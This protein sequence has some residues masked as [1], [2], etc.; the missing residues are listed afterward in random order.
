M[1]EIKYRPLTVVVVD[2]DEQGRKYL[3]T[4][5]DDLGFGGIL[6]AENG[7]A[8]LRLLEETDADVN[9]IVSDV[10]LP[11]M[12]GFGFVRRIRY[13]LVPRFKDVPVLLLT[14]RTTE[15]DIEYARTHKISGLLEKPLIAD[16]VKVQMFKVLGV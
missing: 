1:R 9:L 15:H 2:G 5:F 7:E 14:E 13:G 10:E 8:A 16:V 11:D 3:T 4:L 6:A 12:D